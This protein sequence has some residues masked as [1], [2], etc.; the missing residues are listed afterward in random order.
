MCKY[1][2]VG[3]KKL[4][5]NPIM[6]LPRCEIPPQKSSR[7]KHHLVGTTTSDDLSSPILCS[8]DGCTGDLAA[9]ELPEVEK[10][11]S[12]TR[13]GTLL[14]SPFSTNIS[15]NLYYREFLK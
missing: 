8:V 3:T 14:V 11:P 15:R 4:R 13:G 10:S 5:F 2:P 12:L 1:K 9:N 7:G 6:L